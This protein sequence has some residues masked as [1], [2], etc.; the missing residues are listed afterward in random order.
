MAGIP[1]GEEGFIVVDGADPMAPMVI[2]DP[3]VVVYGPWAHRLR[4]S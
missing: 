4:L 2:E 1:D 3:V